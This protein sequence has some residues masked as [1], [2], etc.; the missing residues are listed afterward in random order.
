MKKWLQD[1]QKSCGRPQELCQL[2]YDIASSEQY[3]KLHLRTAAGA[4]CAGAFEDIRH[5]IGRLNHTLKASKIVVAASTRLPHLFHDFKIMRRKSSCALPPPLQRRD[6][7][8]AAILG[9]MLPDHNQIAEYWE[10]LK[11]LDQKF[12]ISSEI[13]R[14]CISPNWK[15]RVHAEL[16][17]LDWFWTRNLEFVAGDR[18][19]GCSKPACYCCSHYIKAHPGRFVIPACHNNTYLNWRAPD[20]L[21]PKDSAGIKI[22]QGILNEITKKIRIDVLAQIMER[23]GPGKWKPDSMTEIS[24]LRLGI[25]QFSPVKPEPYVSLDWPADESSECNESDSVV[26]NDEEYEIESEAG[27]ESTEEEDSDGGVFLANSSSL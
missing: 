10:A 22:R 23:R 16:I 17:L 9:R 11:E 20:I 1:L 4:P 3:Q 2:C 5:T 14:Q 18:Y 7:T 19:I 12:N 13:H 8:L 15:P 6:P 25:P 27:T 24:S 26:G 21:D